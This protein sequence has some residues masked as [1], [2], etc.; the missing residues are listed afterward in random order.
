M[1]ENY[2][3]ACFAKECRRSL[4]QSFYPKV[5]FYLVF[6]GEFMFISCTL[7]FFLTLPY[8]ENLLISVLKQN[9]NLMFLAI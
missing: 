5:C 4:E 9:P 7:V 2:N 1:L 3:R 6:L 8:C